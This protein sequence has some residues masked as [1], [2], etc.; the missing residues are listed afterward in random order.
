MTSRIALL[1]ALSTLALAFTAL[2]ATGCDLIELP[3]GACEPGERRMAPDDCNTC[4]CEAGGWACTEMACEPPPDCLC[5]AVYAPVCGADGQTYGNAC[6]AGCAEVEVEAEG[7]CDGACPDPADPNVSYL[8]DDPGE[9]ALIDFA[10]GGDARAFADDCGCGCIAND[11]A[12]CGEGE[13]MH[14]NECLTLCDAD[15]GCPDGTA[16]GGCYPDPGCPECEICLLACE[17]VP[18]PIPECVCPEIY[19]PVCGEDGRTYGNACAA[20]C[21]DVDIDFDGE[22]EPPCRGAPGEDVDCG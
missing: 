1:P 21:A 16:C 14:G 22:C 19:A 17:P 11:P 10:C 4:V 12:A 6:E 8:S 3:F 15:E 13:I 5:P 20:D 7:T 9:C 18:A 2:F